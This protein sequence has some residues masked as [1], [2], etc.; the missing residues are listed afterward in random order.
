[1]FSIKPYMSSLIEDWE[2]V[3]RDSLN[4]N[5]LHSRNFMDYHGDRFLDASLL[6][7]DKERPVA[8]FPANRM[9]ERVYSHQGLSYGGLILSDSFPM[10]KLLEIF[11]TIL[12]HYISIQ[13]KS[14]HIKEIP[15]FYVRGHHEWFAYCM[16]ALGAELEKLELSFT[17]PLSA[18]SPRYSKG[19]KWGINKA[20]KH[21]LEI[22]EV[23]DFRP[24]WETVLGPNLWKRHHARPVHSLEE[25]QWLAQRNAPHI[26]QFDV[27]YKGETVAGTTVF[28][29]ET[30]AHTQYI[31]ATPQGKSL[32]ALDL[33]IDRLV[34]HTFAHKAYF[35][36]GTVNIRQ[37]NSLNA[38]LMAWKESFGALPFVHRFY[39]ID[40][41]S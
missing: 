17:I 23:S 27:W 5:F 32:C 39:R 16:Y 24:F 38:G 40:L 30:T 2:L 1:M 12:N 33:L 29:S 14:L 20:K 22:Q 3:A 35:D 41:K 19:R 37:D 26:R 6:V 8:I 4:G 7:Y 18:A 34:T 36:F 15:S 10:E 9:N 31:S 28:E 13:I 25:I 21:G 11:N